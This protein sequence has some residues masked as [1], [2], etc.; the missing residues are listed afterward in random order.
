MISSEE[1]WDSSTQDLKSEKEK[2]VQPQTEEHRGKR[3]CALTARG[4]IS[5]AVTGLVGGAAAG[6]A[7]CR[8]DWTTAMIPRSSGQGT[9]PSGAERA[10]LK[11]LGVEAD[12]RQLAAK[13]ELLRSHMSNWYP[14]S[15][16]VLQASVKDDIIIFCWR[17]TE[18]TVVSGARYPHSSLGRRGPPRRMSFPTQY[19]A[20]VPE[21][22]KRPHHNI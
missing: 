16:Q 2:T 9:H 17:W 7:E 19:A 14:M 20:H 8:Q 5:K 6:S 10:Q 3:A 12:T 22:R 4:S 18:E 15:T 11:Q 21:E 1:F 13:Q